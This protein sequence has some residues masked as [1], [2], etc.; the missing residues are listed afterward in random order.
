M[1][2]RTWQHHVQ[3]RFDTSGACFAKDLGQ[4]VLFE[5]RHQQVTADVE[6]LGLSDALH[7]NLFGGDARVGPHGVDEASILPRHV[8]NQ[9]PRG[10]DIVQLL[11]AAGINAALDQRFQDKAAEGVFAYTANDPHVDPH[12]RQIHGGV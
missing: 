1:I 12:A 9:R 3:N 5:A 6:H 7:V 4:A 8:D 10:S 2:A 11:H